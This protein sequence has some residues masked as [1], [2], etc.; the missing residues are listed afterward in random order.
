MNEEYAV[1]VDFYLETSIQKILPKAYIAQVNENNLTYVEKIATFELAESFNIQNLSNLQSAIDLCNELSLIAITKK[2]N[3]KTNKQKPLSELLKDK[4]FNKIFEQ[5]YALKLDMLLKNLEENNIPF[6]FYLEKTTPF[7]KQQ[8]SFSEKEISPILHFLKTADNILYTLSLK[9]DTETIQP[10]TEKT[11]LIL[12]DPSYIAINKNVYRLK[13]INGNKIKPFI[14]KKSIEI[15]KRTSKTYFK[16]FIKDILNHVEIETEGFGFEQKTDIKKCEIRTFYNFFKNRYLLDIC[17][18]YEDF[19]FSFSNK[20]KFASKMHIEDDIVV[21]QTKRNTTEEKKWIE[22]ATDLG[23]KKTENNFFYFENTPKNED[24]YQQIQELLK[25]KESFIKQGFF[26]EDI[27]V[28][29]KKIVPNSAFISSKYEEKE[30]WFDLKMQISCGDFSFPFSNI[31]ENIRNNN[32]FYELPDGSYFL[33]PRIWF[34]T[35]K[36]LTEFGVIK[37]GQLTLKRNQLPIINHLPNIAIGA[38]CKKQNIAYIP[39]N[40]LKATLRNYQTEGVKWLLDHNQNQLGA[41]LADD[42]GLGKTLQ[43]LAVLTHI[44]DQLNPAVT[45]E[46][47][48][49][50]SQTTLKKEPLKALVIVPSSL[51]FNWKNET[52]K[53]APFLQTIGYTGKDRKTIKRKLHLYDIV[54][55]S[56]PIVLKD[57]NHFKTLDFTYLI[58]DESQYI[59]NKNSKIFKAINSIS[60]AHKITLSGTPIENSLDDLWSLMQFINPDLLGTFTFF[61][62]YFKIPIEKHQDES[63]TEALKN[64]IQPYILRRT[65]EQVAKDLPPILEQVFYSE[66]QPKQQEWY[67]EEKSKARNSLLHANEHPTKINVLNTLMRLRQ[68]G[69]HPKLVVP[70][71]QGDSGKF[72][73]VIEYLQTLIKAGQKIILFSS[74]VK[75]LAIYTQWCKEHHIRFCELTGATKSENRQTEI[76]KFQNDQ[77]VLLF[78][79]SLKAGG[80]GLNLTAA[81]YVV[82]LDPWWNPFAE[83]QAIARAHRIGQKKQVNVVRFIAK[84]TIEEKIRSLQEKKKEI[85]NTIIETDNIPDDVSNNLGYLLS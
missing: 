74:F 35:Y 81:S 65:K 36:D 28:E 43:T 80:V 79:I 70:D 40:N 63:K 34:S 41:C 55:T 69:N 64:L 67:E 44:K 78:F 4:G 25:N 83:N 8:F 15:P 2:Y 76:D 51:V 22:K 26:I 17:F 66:M 30:D 54:F 14:T 19:S 46:P 62:N 57:I 32:P 23:L 24:P 20:K 13:T 45:T 61:K 71:F 59:K 18:V 6:A 50:F 37:N 52:K 42:M 5:Y 38:V 85:S 9:T 21:F 16:T 27:A 1:C 29:G 39:S 31:I 10:Y 60:T 73:D 7:Y 75:H 11:I 58:L 72:L 84:D 47:L 12:N 3:A 49:L 68:I 33:I 77:T 48:D 53:F 82:L 56:Y